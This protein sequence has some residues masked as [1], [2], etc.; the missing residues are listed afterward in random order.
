M[1]E[2]ALL[3]KLD[4]EILQALQENARMSNVDIGDR[5]GLSPSA[6]SRR[7]TQLE[8][9]GYIDGYTVCLSN[10]AL[11]IPI[12]AIVHISLTGQSEKHLDAFERAAKRCPHITACFLMSGASDYI[13]HIHARDMEQFEHIHKNWLSALPGVNRIQ[14]SFAMRGVINRTNVDLSLI[15]SS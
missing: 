9:K 14:S 8:E 2:T 4:L 6:C 10:K 7:I 5:V 15:N 11:G 12:T 3:D 13:A 1:D